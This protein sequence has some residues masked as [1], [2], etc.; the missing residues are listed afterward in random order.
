MYICLVRSPGFYEYWSGWKLSALTPKLL[1]DY[2]KIGTVA[3]RRCGAEMWWQSRIPGFMRV[4][5][6][7]LCSI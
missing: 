2:M 4:H 7:F 1:L 3:E 6:R 5:A